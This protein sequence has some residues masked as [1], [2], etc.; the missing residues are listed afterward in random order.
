M[1]LTELAIKN[2]VT[3]YFLIVVLLIGGYLSYQ[4]SEKA[5]DPGFTIKV[6]LITTNW[7]G[8]TA[9]QMADLVSK[10]IADQVQ[11][12]DSLWYVNSTNTDGQSN[13]YVNIKAEYKDIQPVWTELRNRINTFVV[14]N[15]PQGVQVPQINTFYGD[16]YG[17]LLAIG[18][19]GY[20]Y[21]ELYETAYQLKEVLL[22]NVPQ[23][24]SIDISGIQN[25]TVYI[26]IDNK[27]LSQTGLTLQN[28]I[29]TLNS[30]NVIIKGGNIVIDENRLKVTPSGNFK[31]IEDIKDTIITSPNGDS[32]IY[33]SEVANIYKGYQDPSPYSIDFNG[34]KSL[35]LGISLGSG[36]DVLLMGKG[37]QETLKTYRNSLPIGLEVG[38]IYYLPD[39]V[40]TNVTAFIVN[41]IQAV[42]TI[43]LVMLVFLGLRSGLIVA[44]L[45]PTSIAF[46]LIGLFWFD[47]GINQI[48]LAG[49]I[50]AL[51]M[52]VDNAV[53]MSEN[54]TVLLEEGYSRMDACLE[55]SKTLAIP[56][57]VSSLTTI[58]AF[59]P[60]ILNKQNMGEYVGPLTI[61]VML[62]LM[63]SWLINQTFIPL[64][65]Y[66]FIK[67]KPGEK[68][69]LNS[70]PYLLYREI[71]IK[72]LKNKKIT[73]VLTAISFIFGIWLLG[74]APSNFMPGSTD[75]VMSTY[76]TLP[77]GTDVDHTRAVVEDLN[78]FIEK[79][80][81]TGPQEPLPPGL[82]D[83]ITTGGTTKTYDKAGVLSWGSFIGGGAPRFS[84]GYSPQTQLPEYAYI[85][86][87][88]T[89]YR[90]IPKLS[91]EI[92]QYLINKYP[93]IDV[94]SKGLG[95]GVSLA[96]DL[97]YV[98]ASRD[99][100]LLKKVA[101]EV[102]SKLT[103][104]DGTYAVSD[105][106]G[107]EVPKIFIEVDTE[108][109]QMAG[110]TNDT[111]GTYLQY[112]LQ[113]Y[114]ASVYRN[115]DAPPQSTVIPIVLRG[116]D[117]YKDDLNS[118]QSIEL[119]NSKGQ[120]VPLKQIAKISLEYYD[121]LVATRNM[122]YS[123]E[124]DAA[125]KD[126]TTPL[127]VNKKF[128]PWLDEKLK[129]WGPD[130]KYYSSGI[131][132]T[133]DENQ[134]AL[135]AQVPIAILGMFFLVVAQFNSM[136][137]G[138]T[139]MLVIPLSILGVAIGLLLTNT[140]L[141]F[142]AMIGIIALAGVVL[143][144]AIILV[145]K[146]TIEKDDLGRSDQDAVVFGCQSRLRPIFL[147]VATTL[148][149][150]MPLYFFGGP[151]FQP[152]AV[153]LIFG[154]VTD[155]V[156]ALGVIPVIYALFYKIDFADYKYDE[157]RLIEN[158]PTENKDAQ[159]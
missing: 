103:S 66:D 128:M 107:I 112:V 90:L 96:K 34:N 82:W 36:E 18:G 110:F 21:E 65:C 119:V 151:L 71:L 125:I 45:T 92:N 93:D 7:P 88:L 126:S 157:S 150:L 12:M 84:T 28:I 73:I 5:Q 27:L 33:L 137:K 63:S 77:K 85:M 37:I 109:A 58:M 94:V 9:K 152:V 55:S 53:V 4:K 26:D 75:P 106:W 8:A 79:N 80:Y 105:D 135:F 29:N 89:D 31:S 20:T 134:E 111:I 3:T 72:V 149:G 2:K 39:L 57:F 145:D 129:E 14:P 136:R 32:S 40:Q 47:Y 62:A 140:D 61:V 78:K 120:A 59:S 121:S 130:V 132:Q 67:L 102:K 142:M 147:T 64:L 38:E 159:S 124:I 56:L 104:L 108:K 1:K 6:A 87:N 114:N 22:F 99:I 15:L 16:I 146:M 122:A 141:G 23:I 117:Q 81:S 131:M 25:E 98:F 48:T 43:I 76:I 49:L 113:G 144:H 127:E 51:G 118:I 41:L 95:S 69:N 46:T 123:I 70:K 101:E 68:Q 11:N 158:K 19:D 54:I 13:V 153:V 91:Q 155:T 115:F 52:L 42:T 44:A 156:L 133:S 100:K 148:V 17:T 154:L 60:I 139:I 50:I 83:Y 30:S 97:G 35:V 116:T 86:Y 74:L 138:L 10:R 143:N 24:G